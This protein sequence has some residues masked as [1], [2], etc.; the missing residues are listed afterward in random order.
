MLKQRFYFF[1]FNMTDKCEVARFI[2]NNL[3]STSDRRKQQTKEQ[4]RYLPNKMYQ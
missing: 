1:R 3:R 2:K 4:Y